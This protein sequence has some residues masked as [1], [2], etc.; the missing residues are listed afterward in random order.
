LLGI[1]LTTRIVTVA[2]AVF[3]PV[4]LITLRAIANTDERLV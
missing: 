4:L 2:V 3:F 1:G